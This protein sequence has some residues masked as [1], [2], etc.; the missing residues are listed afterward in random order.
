MGDRFQHA[1]H[2]FRVAAVLAAGFVVFLIARSALIPSDFGVLG[3]YRA[4][5]LDDIKALP[6]AYAGRSACMECHDG[7][8]D[9]PERDDAPA[10]KPAVAVA[11]DP[12]R[13]NKHF[14][15]NCEACHGPLQ[16][17]VED[18]E[19][20]VP[21][22]VASDDLC[23]GCHR[24]LVGRPKTQPQVVPADH[25]KSGDAKKDA[26]VACHTPHWPKTPE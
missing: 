3:Y 7:A 12:A 14:T 5:A 16:K 17:H 25:K 15:L 2:V 10:R 19:K 9:A 22:K 20:A 11:L 26:C 6:I 13:D 8:Y 1:R 21:P 24:T 23:L 4:G 18:Q